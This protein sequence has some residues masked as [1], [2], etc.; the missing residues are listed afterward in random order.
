[1]RLI[2][3]SGSLKSLLP[4]IGGEVVIDVD[5]IGILQW[6]LLGISDEIIFYSLRSLTLLANSDL[7]KLIKNKYW[8]G[9]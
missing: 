7:G 8:V 3:S 1:M 4:C 5:T 9:Y 6:R 2:R